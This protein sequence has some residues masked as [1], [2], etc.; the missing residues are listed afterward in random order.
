MAEIEID[1]RELEALAK[2]LE[3]EART[4]QARRN[5]AALT[6]GIDYVYEH[7]TATASGFR[8]TGAMLAATRKVGRGYTRAVRCTDPAGFFN[9]FGTVHMPPRPW[10]YVEAD[11]GAKVVEEE[12]ARSLDDFL[13]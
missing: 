10:L 11:P 4:K 1:L 12:L 7:A 2:G 13:K 9:E 8:D 3:E 5:N 6:K